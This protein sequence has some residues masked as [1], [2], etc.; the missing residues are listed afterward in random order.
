[1]KHIYWAALL[2]ILTGCSVNTLNKPKIPESQPNIISTSYYTMGETAY[3]NNDFDAAIK[4]FKRAA[5]ADP[6][7]LHIKERLLETLAISSYYKQEYQQELIE[8]GEKYYGKGIYSV[9]MLLILADAFRMTE[10]FEKANLY[11]QIVVDTDPTLK[12]LTLFYIFQKEYYPPAD[13]K[14]LDKAAK[15]PW[16]SRDE[17]IMLGSLLG[18]LDPD[19]GTEILLKAYE[20][21]DDEPSLKPLLTAF[22]KAGKQDKIL[23]EIQ[24]RVDEDKYISEGIVTFMI[25]KYFA[26]HQYE[27]VIQNKEVCYEVGSEEILKYLF[28]SA[29][30]L[31]EYE[32][33][34]EA[35]LTIEQF[36][37]IPAE[38]KPSFYS[39]LAKLYIDTD[40]H[41]KSVEYLVKCHDIS[42]I[43]SLMFQYDIEN[44]TVQREKLFSLLNDY[45]TVSGETDAVN[46]LF[47]ILY[48]QLEN[49]E[50]A[51]K[52]I[53]LVSK[54]YLINNKLAFP[55]ATIY[56]QNTLD[57][58]KARELIELAPDP[59]YT[60]NEIISSLLYNTGHDSLAFELCLLEFSENPEPN[61]ST[62]LRYSI[63]ADKLDSRQNMIKILK[64]GMDDYPEN[65]D[66]MNALGYMIAKYEMTENYD[67]AHQ[68]LEKAVKLAPDSEMIWDSLAWLYFKDGDTQK[69][70]TAMNIPLSKEI[71]NSEIAYHL[72][73]I[74]LNLGQN[75]LARKYLE[76]AIQINDDEDAVKASQK[77]LEKF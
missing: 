15:L 3:Q 64:N 74:Y 43:R 54:D 70:M 6:G 72:G 30:S 60:S 58:E 29:I 59:D 37:N 25:G 34:I 44:N 56:L 48:T 47:S 63:L 68:L 49:K 51:I 22:E 40:N 5:L 39:Y 45:S 26:L 32:L 23:E 35:G 20:R 57:I 41:E 11:Y 61:V 42:V 13:K 33:G 71:Q 4:L 65:V 69:A 17:V 77:L 16:K 9:K 31:N 36:D 28:F 55:A 75:K 53:E 1:M 50:Q 76:L 8:L 12:N 2:A 73:A 10:N 67:L 38:L 18:E 14:L 52:Y 7:A 27:K 24:Q 62:Y 66:L 21:W 19:R 46:Y